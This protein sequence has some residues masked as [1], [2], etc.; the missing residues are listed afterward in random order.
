M[1]MMRLLLLLFTVPIVFVFFVPV[2][3]CVLP[4]SVL[5]VSVLLI[6]MLKTVEKV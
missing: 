6:V 4:M 1:M 2:T 5:L 3:L